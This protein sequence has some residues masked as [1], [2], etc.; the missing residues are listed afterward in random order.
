MPCVDSRAQEET[1]MSNRKR[2]VSAIV[3]T[4]K[5]MVMYCNR[6]DRQIEE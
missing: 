1:L 6:V 2:V 5:A 4:G 3:T